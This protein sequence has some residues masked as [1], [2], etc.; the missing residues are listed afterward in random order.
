MGGSSER[1][2][3]RRE[4]TFTV[5]RKSVGLQSVEKSD[6]GLD[7]TECF[8]GSRGGAFFGVDGGEMVQ[9]KGAKIV[10]HELDQAREENCRI[11]RRGFQIVRSRAA[12]RVGVCV[13]YG[14]LETGLLE[15]DGQEFAPSG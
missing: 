6:M 12:I 10:P 11:Q 3:V 7:V 13:L 14:V 5:S 15:G 8:G 1:F 9:P 2:D 4:I